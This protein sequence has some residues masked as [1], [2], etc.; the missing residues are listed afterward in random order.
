MGKHLLLRGEAH[1]VSCGQISG[2]CIHHAPL[3]GIA[4][5][6]AKFLVAVAV[7]EAPF[8]TLLVS[9]PRSPLLGGAN[10]RRARIRAVPSATAATSAK[11]QTSATTGAASL[12]TELEHRKPPPKSWLPHEHRRSCAHT[13]AAHLSRMLEQQ[14]EGSERLTPGLRLMGLAIV[15]GVVPSG[16]ISG[17]AR[18]SAGPLEVVPD[19]AGGS[20][21]HGIDPHQYLDEVLRIL[22]YWPKER[23]LELAPKSWMAT[24]AKLR[25]D[26][27]AA[28]LC[29]FTIPAA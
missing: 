19:H 12:D 1:L 15:P 28:P 27:L 29:S 6:S 16:R 7:I 13:S 22:P 2:R 24:R 3:L 4:P 18:L 21:L 14:P 25:P 26:E 10:N 9:P 5:Q 17:R 11:D 8:G 23:H 20:S